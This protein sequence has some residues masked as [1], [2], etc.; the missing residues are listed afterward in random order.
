MEAKE[1]LNK[2]KGIVG[3]ELTAE[4]EPIK[5]ELIETKLDNG[6]VI[7]YDELKE[8]SPVFI[9][10][11]DENIALPVGRYEHDGKILVVEEDG[12]IARIEDGEAKVDVDV[13]VEEDMADV[14][15]WEGMEKRIQNLEDA[16]SGLKRDHENMSKT[17][18]PKTEISKE[19]LSAIE[20]E[21]EPI[22]H[23]PENKADTKVQFKETENP[24]SI[25]N[26]VFNIINK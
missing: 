11:E 16:V 3:I 12:V 23:S 1:I 19:T 6:T 8:G 17:E 4:K 7:T 5:V 20:V 10:S 24:D 9:V 2:I 25:L 22:Y 14:G 21:A 15:D 13:E 18:A 26:R